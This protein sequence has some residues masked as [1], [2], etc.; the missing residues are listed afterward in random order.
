MTEKAWNHPIH[1]IIFD[2]D[3]TTLD[4]IPAYRETTNMVIGCDYGDELQNKLNG[5]SE[6]KAAEL[7]VNELHLDMTAQELIDRRKSLLHEKL[8]DSQP[9][10]GVADFIKRLKSKGYKVGLATSGTRETTNLKFGKHKELLGLFDIV[11]CGDE[12]KNA[13][14]SPEI[15]L[16][17]ASK[18]GSKPE[19]SL[20]FED[21]PNG[22]K[23]ANAAN[24]PCALFTNGTEDY[25]KDSFGAKA[26]Y[27]FDNYSNFD[28]SVFIWV[29]E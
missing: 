11:V 6:Y 18:L 12:V 3:G 22:I 10:P 17:C 29:K 9:F 19:N 25:K 27:V 26:T 2:N 1:A 14:P 24:M 23:A 16:T 21:T 28:E 20:V 5:M 7:V 13:K 8:A 4:T 15:F